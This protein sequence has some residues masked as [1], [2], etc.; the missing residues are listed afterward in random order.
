MAAAL[1][2]HRSWQILH[3]AV[4]RPSTAREAHSA[5]PPGASRRLPATRSAYRSVQDGRIMVLEE[6]SVRR[7][8]NPAGLLDGDRCWPI[9]EFSQKAY[10]QLPAPSRHSRSKM[11][12]WCRHLQRFID[13]VTARPSSG[14]VQP[15]FVNCTTSARQQGF[16]LFVHT[17]RSP[18]PNF[19]GPVK[20]FCALCHGKGPGTVALIG[21]SVCARRNCTSLTCTG[22]TRLMG[23]RHARCHAHSSAIWPGW[24]ISTPSAPWQTVE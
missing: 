15:R 8:V 22:H 19:P 21:R 7:P 24:S 6:N 14:L 2:G 13:A 18:S 4:R 17:W 11:G 20:S 16:H 10:R 3:A 1:I 5:R 23:P 12:P 9:F